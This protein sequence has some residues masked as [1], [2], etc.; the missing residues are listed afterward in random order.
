M[1]TDIRF[2][3][4]D[5]GV[6]YVI[7]SYVLNAITRRGMKAEKDTIYLCLMAVDY[8]NGDYDEEDDIP[9]EEQDEI[10]RMVRVI[11]HEDLHLAIDSCFP[12]KPWFYMR[13]RINEACIINGLLDRFCWKAKYPILFGHP[14]WNEYSRLIH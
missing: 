10:G 4:S 5:D 14:E 12:S 11:R 6:A 2:D 13:D 1:S 8:L 7:D 3:F 9:L